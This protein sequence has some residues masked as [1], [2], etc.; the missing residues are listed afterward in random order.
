MTTLRFTKGVPWIQAPGLTVSPK[1]VT[2]QRDRALLQA[3][4]HRPQRGPRP[5][6]SADKVCVAWPSEPQGLRPGAPRKMLV[7]KI[8]YQRYCMEDCR[9]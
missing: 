3:L 6:P 9:N 8:I 5:A 7:E 1:E 2:S 4:C